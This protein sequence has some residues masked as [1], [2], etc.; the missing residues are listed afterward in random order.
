VL[1]HESFELVMQRLT[2][3]TNRTVPGA[4]EVSITMRD[5]DP[6]TVAST[7][8]FAVAVDECQYEAGYGPCLDALRLGTTVTV[9]DQAIEVRWPQ[10]SPRAVEA[11]VGSSVSVPL[12]VADEHVAALNIY[13][14]VPHAFTAQAVLVA[15]ELAVYAGAVLNNADMYYTAAS[16]AEQMTEAMGSRAVIEQ[17]KG[18]LM[19]GRRCN[20]DAAFDILVKLSQRSHQKLRVVAQSIIDHVSAD[21]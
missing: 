8:A 21:E 4:F 18:V 11:G 13:G 7:A 17:A 3:I 10:Y 15:E 2:L 5:R 9:E 6:V 20:A 19:A 14:D 12:Q 16:L 1:A